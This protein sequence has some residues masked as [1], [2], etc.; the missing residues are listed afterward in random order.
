MHCS[1]IP[2]VRDGHSDIGVALLSCLAQNS[3][4][5]DAR[6]GDD[7]FFFWRS[8]LQ[9]WNN[10]EG[11]TEFACLETAELDSNQSTLSA[12]PYY[13]HVKTLL[14]CENIL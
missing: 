9:R 10:G 1:S 6:S 7:L 3:A 13:S 8:L 11:A 2:G 5:N 12:W 14:G 4:Q